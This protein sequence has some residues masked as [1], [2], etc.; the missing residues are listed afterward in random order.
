MIKY[1]SQHGEDFLLDKIFEHKEEGFFVEVG[2]IDGKKFSNTLAF[3]EMG[4]KGM[5]VEAH[6]G[7]IE[8]LEKNRPGSIIC[9]CAA[10]ERDE[11]DVTFYANA[12]GSLST[13][14]KTQ[15]QRW[16]K[17]FNSYFSGF[18]E[19][20]VPMRR[21]DTLLKAFNIREIDFISIDVEGY[22][23]EVLKGIDLNKFRPRVFVIES[24]TGE[25]KKHTEAIL[26]PAG[27]HEIGRLSENIFYSYD[28]TLSK[29]IDNKLFK[30][31]TLI[32]TEHPLDNTGDLEV[33]VDIDMRKKNYILEKMKAATSSFM[34]TKPQR[35]AAR[36]FDFYNEGFHGDRYLLELVDHLIKNCSL[37]IET[38]T[39]VGSTLAYV[40]KKY[41]AIQCLSCEPDGDAYGEAVKN[42]HGL[43]NV[44]LYNATSQ[45]FMDIIARE[46]K[47]VFGEKGF[48]WLDSH[49]YGFQ[50]PLREEIS[51]ITTHFGAAYILVDDF[52]VP[53]LDCFGWDEYE[54]QICSFEYISG[55]I[56]DRLAYSLYYPA[57]TD[58]TSKHHAL[59]GWGLIA[60][61]H[62]REL[63]IPSGLKNRI[64]KAI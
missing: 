62:D 34:R 42:T 22:E 27:Y 5:C 57:Y 4:W 56:K 50:W 55:S 10:A 54:G 59:R 36:S 35:N 6:A 18:Q 21:L 61:G 24:D 29:K 16:Q 33:T 52:K 58:R 64:K 25:H 46:R 20:K 31:V 8:L 51:F 11:E 39:N 43:L 45:E 17:E 30:N 1:Y 23:V 26:L 3:E 15:E 32:H 9:H 12:R 60:F 13:L 44:T 19:Q 40:A 38:G 37:F 63:E 14:D 2:C 48:F 41:P 49:G 47:D 7:F 28:K 53:G